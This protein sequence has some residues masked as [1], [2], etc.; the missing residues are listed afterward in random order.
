[1]S[2]KYPSPAAPVKPVVLTA[3]QDVPP[4][5]STK[6]KTPEPSVTIT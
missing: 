5:L 2:Q 4:E 1:V 6:D 3:T